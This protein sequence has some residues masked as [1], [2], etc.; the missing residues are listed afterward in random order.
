MSTE[1]KIS[2]SE[3]FQGNDWWEWAVWV[4]GSD[5]ALDKVDYVEWTLHSTFR[6][7]I[8]KVTNR[9][10]KFRIDTGGWGEFQIHARV[11]TKDD[12]SFRLKHNLSLRYPSGKRASAIEK[13]HDIQGDNYQGIARQVAKLSIGKGPVENFK[14][15]KDLI[16]SLPPDSTMMAHVP[17]ITNNANSARVKEEQRNIRVRAF[18]YA[19]RKE[20]NNDFALIVGR[21]ESLPEMY[22]IMD[23]SG[24]PPL[25]SKSF[26]QLNAARTQFK[27]FF[28]SGLPGVSYDFYYPPIPVEVEGSLFF[29]YGHNF[30]KPGPKSLR[31]RIHSKHWEVH[32]ITKIVFNP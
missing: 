29:N 27:D 30:D 1:F 14:E 21:N 32:P 19:A 31:S 16:D 9:A 7:P 4:E 15:L 10:Q 20:R 3:T 6:D 25:S 22:M 18:L 12:R 2:Q 17:P 23:M 5:E 11:R 24:L 28:G 8:R 26:P 13:V